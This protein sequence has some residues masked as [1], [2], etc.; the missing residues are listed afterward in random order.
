MCSKLFHD[1]YCVWHAAAEKQVNGFKAAIAEEKRTSGQL[2]VLNSMA[3]EKTAQLEKAL[4]NEQNRVS[5]L[6]GKISFYGDAYKKLQGK[7]TGD[8]YSKL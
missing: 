4:A 5:D 6:S 3:N 8:I 2:R 7:L 1:L